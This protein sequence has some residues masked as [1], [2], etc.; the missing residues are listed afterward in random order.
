MTSAHSVLLAERG[1][2]SEGGAHYVK[3]S[4]LSVSYRAYRAFDTFRLRTQIAYLRTFLCVWHDWHD[5]N[6]SAYFTIYNIY[7]LYI[8]I[9]NLYYVYI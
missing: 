1:L 7:T 8:P 6:G 3:K 5:K 4:V 9:I 2:E